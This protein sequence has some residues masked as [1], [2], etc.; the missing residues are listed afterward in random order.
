ML[1]G[2]GMK[3]CGK[4]AT[5]SSKDFTGSEAGTLRTDVGYVIR[6][7]LFFFFFF[8]LL[9]V[10]GFVCLFWFWFVLG[11]LLCHVGAEPWRVIE[12]SPGAGR[13]DWI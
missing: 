5:F 4:K 2:A 13:I 12:V 10:W 1:L 3:L 6:V 9:V 11:L 8:T 7:W